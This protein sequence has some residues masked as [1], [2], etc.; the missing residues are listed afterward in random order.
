[1]TEISLGERLELGADESL[2]Y[3][4]GGHSEDQY[5]IDSANYWRDRVFAYGVKTAV[6]LRDPSLP[7]LLS[8]TDHGEEVFPAFQFDPSSGEL[9]PKAAIVNLALGT[10]AVSV[11]LQIRPWEMAM[12][13]VDDSHGYMDEEDGAPVDLLSDSSKSDLLL[14]AAYDEIQT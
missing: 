14:A 6:E 12:W 7:G 2:V 1:M 11:E 8:V 9:N 3:L 10:L 13:W 4:L 5:A